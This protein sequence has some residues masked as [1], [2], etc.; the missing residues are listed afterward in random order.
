MF[1]LDHNDQEPLC[2]QLYKQIKEAEVNSPFSIFM[3]REF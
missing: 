2:K 3:T 1:I